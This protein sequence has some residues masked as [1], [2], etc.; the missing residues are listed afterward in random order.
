[1]NDILVKSHVGD[2]YLANLRKPFTPLKNS[3]CS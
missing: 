1:M 2:T 3:R